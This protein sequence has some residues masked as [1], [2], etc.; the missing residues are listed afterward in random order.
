MARLLLVMLGSAVGGGARYLTA[1]WVQSWTG[2]AFPSGTLA[3]N[4]VGS[5]L[6]CGVMHWSTAT[7][8]SAE[9]RLLLTSGLLGGFTTYSTF[10]YETFRLVQESAWGLAAANV[11]A[12]VL[13]CFAAGVLGWWL[14]RTL[15]G[16]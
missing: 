8:I 1:G 15:A 13:T 10:D 16:A 5:F 9:T 11:I 6:I 7:G 3:V 12:T 2:P 14:S 4:A